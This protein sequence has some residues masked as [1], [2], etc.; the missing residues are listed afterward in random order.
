[1]LVVFWR[2][3]EGNLSLVA[4]LGDQPRSAPD[5]PEK[6]IFTHGEIGNGTIAPYTVSIARTSS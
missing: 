2:F 5:W 6:P 3:S 1:M 4:N